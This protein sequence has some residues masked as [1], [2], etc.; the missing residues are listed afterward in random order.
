MAVGFA[1]LSKQMVCVPKTSFEEMGKQTNGKG[2]EMTDEQISNLISV[3]VDRAFNAGQ[4]FE[5]Q[6]LLF[7]LDN[8]PVITAWFTTED[9]ARLKKLVD[10][11]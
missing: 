10:R 9:L 5:K 4:A 6:R 3:A 1:L 2:K 7:L 8:D 11:G